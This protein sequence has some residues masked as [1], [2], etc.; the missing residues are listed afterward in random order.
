MIDHPSRELSLK[1][2]AALL[3]LSRSSLYYEPLPPSDEEIAVKH[4]IDELYTRYPFYGSRRM[5]V[6]LNQEHIVI[7][8]PTVQRYMREMGISGIAPGP[9]TSKL[10]PEHKIYPYL[11]RNVQAEAPDQIW[12][13]DITYIRLIGGW[14]YL[15]AVLDWYSRYVI[16]WELDQSLEIPFVLDAVD[17][18]LDQAQPIIWNSDQGSHFTSPRYI[19]RLKAAGVRISMDGRGRAMDNIFTERLW[20]SLKY[21]EVYLN[22]YE[23]PRE[24][25]MGITRYFNFYNFERPH[26]A[27]GYRTPA[28]VYTAKDSAMLYSNSRKESTLF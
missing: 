6:M 17:H 8:R 3:G 16:T 19:D 25:R 13:I 11:L 9:N 18:A 22:D 4:R 15:V 1:A 26:Q 23:S 12:G 20:R 7:S 24:A 27:L 28:Q 14:M 21:E 10:A 2:Q 5:T